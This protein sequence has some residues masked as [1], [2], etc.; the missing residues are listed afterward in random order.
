M[1]GKYQIFR[2]FCE[3]NDISDLIREQNKENMVNVLEAHRE[4]LNLM[5]KYDQYLRNES[6][7]MNKFWQQY[8]DMV[9]ILFDFRKSVRDGIGISILQL[10]SEC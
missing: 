5:C 10:Q 9:E 7:P 8:L 1:K 2:D 3:S 4:L 6:G